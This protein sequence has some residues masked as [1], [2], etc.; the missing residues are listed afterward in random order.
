M[1]KVKI[2]VKCLIGKRDYNGKHREK[3]LFTAAPGW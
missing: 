1:D 2:V 3:L